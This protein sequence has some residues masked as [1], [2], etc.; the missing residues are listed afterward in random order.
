MSSL[1]QSSGPPV[2]TQLQLTPAI[3]MKAPLACTLLSDDQPERIELWASILACATDRKDV[4]DGLEFAFP[5]DAA[6][7]GRLSDVIRSELGAVRSLISRSP[8]VLTRQRCL[9]EHLDIRRLLWPNCSGDSR[10]RFG[11][12]SMLV[13]TASPCRVSCPRLRCQVG[14]AVGG[15]VAVSQHLGREWRRYLGDEGA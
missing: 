8:R 14:V 3:Q 9:C 13:R 10:A 2:L 12:R 4:E 6:F 5:P 7:A 1:I 15:G 11:H